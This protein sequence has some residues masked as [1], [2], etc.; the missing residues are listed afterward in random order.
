MYMDNF[1]TSPA[2]FSDL[3]DMGFSACGTVR[4][5]RRG[6]PAEFKQSL[7]KG[8]VR[9]VAIDE[10]ITAPKWADKRQVHMLSTL[11][12]DAMVTKVRRT[13]HAVGGREEVRKPVMVEEYNKFI[14]GVD[15]SD[16]LLLYYGFSHRTVKWWRRAFFHLLDLAIV[17]AYILYSNSTPHLRAIQNRTC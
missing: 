7:A 2:L 3:R 15:K 8:E 5:N 4:T 17:N 14:G 13:R 11:H 10:G 16:Q 1:Y 6:M 12:D 9:S